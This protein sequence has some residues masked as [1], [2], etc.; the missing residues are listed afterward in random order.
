MPEYN[1][2]EM[3]RLISE[4]GKRIYRNT[5]RLIRNGE[6]FLNAISIA[7]KNE[8]RLTENSLIRQFIEDARGIIIDSLGRA[9]A[10]KRYRIRLSRSS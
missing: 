6:S 1:P 10:E 8:V 5:L 7:I 4:I 2:S 3:D 9:F